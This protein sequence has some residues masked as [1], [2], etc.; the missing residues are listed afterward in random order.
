M[1]RITSLSQSREEAILKIEGRITGAD[2]ALLDREI[3]IQFE[4]VQ[5]L[6]LDLEGLKHIDREGLQL[7]K[8]W[9]GEKLVLRDSSVFVRTLLE[10][11]GIEL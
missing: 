7:L 8:H 2:V 3:R 1:L 5:C 10:T 6:V 9:S 11:H 4:Q